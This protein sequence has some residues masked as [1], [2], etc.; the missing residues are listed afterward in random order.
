MVGVVSE[1]E[2]PFLNFFGLQSHRPSNH[3]ISVLCFPVKG[4]IDK[5][6]GLPASGERMVSSFDHLVPQ[7]LVHSGHNGVTEVPCIEGFDD[8]FVVERAIEPNAGARGS[9]RRG[10]LLQNP[11]Q[12]SQ[13]PEEACTLPV[14]SCIPRL[15]PLRPSLQRIGA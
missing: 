4:G 6:G 2:K 9:D 14:L 5:L 8:L 15:K 10:Q 13:A 11:L 3:H 12:K 1:G 7:R